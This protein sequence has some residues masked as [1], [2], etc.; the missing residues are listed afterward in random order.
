[1]RKNLD[2]SGLA[3]IRLNEF[4]YTCKKK[5]VNYAIA[6]VLL[7]KYPDFPDIYIEEIAYLAQTTISSVSK[8]CKK[9][10]YNSFASLKNDMNPGVEFAFYD[11]PFQGCP[12][13]ADEKKKL[14]H[15]LDSFLLMEM[16]FINTWLKKLDF[17]KIMQIGK[18]LRSCERV[19]I[20]TNNFAFSAG[21]IMRE[22][23]GQKGMTVYEVDRHASEEVLLDIFHS[24][25]M[26]FLISLTDEW[27]VNRSE[28][29]K[30]PAGVNTEIILITK[31]NHEKYQEL[32]NDIV[33]LECDELLLTLS[34]YQSLKMIEYVLIL[35]LFSAK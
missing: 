25:E 18:R 21:N 28:F 24:V 29:L 19:A 1:M 8:F 31:N 9:L 30:T 26:V 17:N 15:A 33:S 3:F 4:F 10:G 23:L 13:E 12:L 2:N 7:S 6:K 16:E 14:Y 27:I 11:R 32:F 22:A 5:D 20:L 35:I 34:S